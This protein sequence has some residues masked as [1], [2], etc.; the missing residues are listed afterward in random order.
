[1]SKK[2]WA[3]N[4]AL[5][6]C[7]GLLARQWRLN[8]LAAQA[9]ERKLLAAKIVPA[10]A[11]ALQLPPP[12]APLQAAAYLDVAQNM[13]F[14]KDRN[15]NVVVE[16]P[17]PKPMPPFPKFYGVMN[18]GDG[19]MAILS[20]RTGRQQPYKAGDK[21]GEFKLASIGREELVFEWDGKKLAKKFSELMDRSEAASSEQ[22]TRSAAPAQPAA[23]QSLVPARPGPGA[24]MGGGLSACNP[25][26][27]SPP[28]T[29][30]DGKRKVVTESPFGK[31]C[32]WEPVR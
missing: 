2:L 23:P 10:P 22:T 5:L 24:D 13:L 6:A 30:I 29:V 31:V 4:L 8:W 21:V 11:P 19:A 20:E 16:T 9:R 3:L 27:P 14:A 26:D 28:G 18:L 12:P 32:R 17:A 15:P 7:L 25:N 1:M